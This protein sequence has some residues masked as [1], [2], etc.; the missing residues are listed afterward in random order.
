MNADFDCSYLLAGW[1]QLVRVLS[2]HSEVINN[3][4][5]MRH[6]SQ[7]GDLYVLQKEEKVGLNLTLHTRTD[8]RGLCYSNQFFIIIPFIS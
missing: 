2:Q 5:Q 3:G 4:L 1:G 6:L 7:H 8:K